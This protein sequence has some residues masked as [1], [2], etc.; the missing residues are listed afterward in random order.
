[1][2][3]SWLSI[4]VAGFAGGIA[5]RSLFYFDIWFIALFAL[6]AGALFFLWRIKRDRVSGRNTIALTA[7]FLMALS[8]G[9]LRMHGASLHKGDTALLRE[10]T[11]RVTAEGVVIREPDV[12]EKATLLY[13]RLD[14][15][16]H[17]DSVE[18]LSVATTVLVTTDVYPDYSYGDRLLLTGLLALPE[19]FITDNGRTFDYR[20]YLSKDGVFYTLFFP[21]IQMVSQGEG[22]RVIQ[23]LLKIK[24]TFLAPMERLIPAPQSSLLAGLLVGA[25][26]SLGAAVQD[27]FRRAGLVHI[28]V[29]SGYNITIIADSV[30]RFFSLFFR[31]AFSLPLGALAIVAFALSVGGG[32][33]VV[34][35]SVMALLALLSQAT[36]RRYDITR[37]LT[38][39]AVGMLVHNPMILLFDPSFQLSFLA[40]FGLIV[41]APLLTPHVRFIPERWKLREMVVATLATQLFVLPLLLYMTGVLPLL[42]LPANLLVLPLVPLTM[43]VGFLTGVGGFV[44]DLIALPFAW[45]SYGLL[46]YIIAVV[47]ITASLPFAAFAVPAFSPLVLIGA[48]GFYSFILARIKKAG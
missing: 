8:L 40:T 44:H 47:R 6:C 29:L 7:L 21:E 32:A 14:R 16:V 30:M 9:A 46:S 12:R 37:A 1:M 3:S 31:R 18:P 19:V 4:G 43:L 35:A 15:L 23:G 2:R 39:A 26:H 41:V 22:N 25:K 36:R 42:A 28:I 11:R 33:T 24:H 5:L 27:D 45:I 13:V 10:V 34:R 17:E 20:S 48:Y 38:I